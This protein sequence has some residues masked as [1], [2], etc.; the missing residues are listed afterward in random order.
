MIDLSNYLIIPE[1]YAVNDFKNGSKALKTSK[2]TAPI[3]INSF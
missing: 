2:I 3:R 1:D